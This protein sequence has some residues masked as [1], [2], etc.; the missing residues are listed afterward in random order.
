MYLDISK[1][2][3]TILECVF[4]CFIL[5]EVLFHSTKCGLNPGTLH[6]YACQSDEKMRKE[7]RDFIQNQS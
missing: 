6:M 2:V 1:L 5:V 3:H 7:S 4:T